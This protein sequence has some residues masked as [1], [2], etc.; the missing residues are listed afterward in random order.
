MAGRKTPCRDINFILKMKS[1]FI[2]IKDFYQQTE[3]IRENGVEKHI[4][5]KA[6]NLA[7]EKCKNIYFPKGKYYFNQSITL[8]S[9][10]H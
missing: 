3:T 10:T 6:F 4:Y 5:N 2:N 8:T 1:K 7:L 9:N